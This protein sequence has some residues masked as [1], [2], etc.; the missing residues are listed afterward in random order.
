MKMIGAIA[1][2]MIGNEPLNFPG[3][4]NF[5]L[6]HFRRVRLKFCGCR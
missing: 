1:G 4:P 5:A 2:D 6:G 3:I